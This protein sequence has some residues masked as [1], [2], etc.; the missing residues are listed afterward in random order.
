MKSIKVPTPRKLPSGNWFIQLSVNGQR[1][2]VT[3]P[4]EKACIARAMAIK[5]DILEP[6]DRSKKP[7]L[8]VAIDRYIEARQ[9]VLSP[10]TIRGYRTIQRNR[11]KAAI[12]RPVNAY[13]EKGWQRLVNQE[14]KIVSAKTLENAWGFVS[15]VIREETGNRYSVSLPQVISEPREYLEPEQIQ[16]FISAVEGTKYQIPALLALCSLRRSEIMALTWKDIDLGKG[17]LHLRGAVVP[18]ENNKM[19]KKEENKNTTSRRTVPIM[20]PQLDEALKAVEYKEDA[21]VRMHPSSAA[22]G[23]NAICQKAGL[24]LVGMHGLRHSFASLA[25]HLKMPE[26]VAMEIG[27]WADDATMR[28]IYTHVAKSDISKYQNAMADFYKNT[29]EI[30]NE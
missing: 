5:Q 23:I 29:N 13:D 22:R 2:S 30:T 15:S 27:G 25:Y 19:V 1:I 10:A 20:I 21:V 3:E 17:L 16:E 12:N 8:S 18:D 14:A 24:P 26:K 11:F 6:V 4:T 28:R 9:N 7:S